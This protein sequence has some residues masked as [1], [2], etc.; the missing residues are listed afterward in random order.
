LLV[1]FQSFILK[2]KKALIF[3]LIYNTNSIVLREIYCL[4]VSRKIKEEDIDNT[5]KWEPYS[6][7]K[8]IDEKILGNC[9]AFLERT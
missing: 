9:R 8:K 4:N 3:F 1:L 2:R 5:L 6:Y 7:L